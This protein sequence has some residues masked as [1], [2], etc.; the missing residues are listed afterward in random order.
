[1]DGLLAFDGARYSILDIYDY[2]LRTDDAAVRAKYR[3][4]IAKARA[5]DA[6]S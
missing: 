1:M 5:E 3:E 4:V 2:V 6:Q